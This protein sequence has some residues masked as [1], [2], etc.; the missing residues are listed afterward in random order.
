MKIIINSMSIDN[1]LIILIIYYYIQILF[2]DEFQKKP[3]LAY[4]DNI[5][6]QHLL[7]YDNEYRYLFFFD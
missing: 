2:K 3:M 1:I 4:N 5:L 7:K 6:K